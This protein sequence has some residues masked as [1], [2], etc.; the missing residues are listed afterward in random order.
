M[1]LA[2]LT[3]LS[4]QRDEFHRA[5]KRL[6]GL[7]YEESRVDAIAAIAR[8]VDE[9]D[10]LGNEGDG[11]ILKVAQ[12]LQDK[13]A[14]GLMLV[15]C[16][17]AERSGLGS[18]GL[19]QKE[20]QALIEVGRLGEAVRRAKTLAAGT[21]YAKPGT[22]DYRIWSSAMGNVGR[23]YK[24]GYMNAA[25]NRV[26]DPAAPA[27]SPTDLERSVEIYNAVWERSKRDVEAHP[28]VVR[29]PSTYHGIN[30]AALIIR[31]ERDRANPF[32]GQDAEEF[33][34]ASGEAARTLAEDILAVHEEDLKAAL[35]PGTRPGDIWTLATCGEAYLVLGYDSDAAL[36]YG[37]YAGNP[38]NDAFKIA[39]SLR[40]LEEVWGI[41]GDDDDTRGQIVRILKTALLNLQKGKQSAVA[42][43]APEDVVQTEPVILTPVE[44]GLIRRDLEK[45]RE[46]A[47]DPTDGYQ[48][49]FNKRDEVTQ[50]GRMMAMD[51][52]LGAM[53]RLR[54]I[55]AIETI[56]GSDW[57][58]IGSG[59]FVDGGVFR[60]DWAGQPLIATNYH[61]VGG[62]DGVMA[63]SYQR[64]R[65]VFFEYDPI[66]RTRDETAI[67][68][69]AVAWMSKPLHHDITLLR[70]K[71]PLPANAKPLMPADVSDYLPV[72][73]ALDEDGCDYNVVV[74]GFPLGGEPKFSF[75]DELL[76]DHSVGDPAGPVRPV[77][78]LDGRPEQLHYRTPTE[79]GSSG[80]PVFDS[81]SWALIGIHHKGS[82]NLKRIPSKSGRYEA[83]QGI[84]IPSIRAAINTPAAVM[85]DTGGD[86]A[87]DV[88]AETGAEFA[89]VAGAV[90]GAVAGQIASRIGST[91]YPDAS[92]T[93]RASGHDTV[94]MGKPLGPP[95]YSA[96]STPPS[97]LIIPGRRI[98]QPQDDPALLERL[99]K[100]GVYS[101]D[102][103]AFRMK[104]SGFET[105]IGDDNRT[106]IHA[107][108]AYP[109]RMICSL[110]MHWEGGTQTVG[111]GFLVGQRTVLTAGHCI[112]PSRGSPYPTGIE[113]RPGRA[114][115]HEPFAHFGSLYAEKV[116]LH[117]EWSNRFDPRFDVGALHLN[118]EIGEELGWFRVAARAPDSLKKQWVHVTGYPGDKVTRLGEGAESLYAAELW[119]HAT[120]V[121]MVHDGRVYY[122][123]DTF[124]GQSGSPVYTYDKDGVATVVGV[125]AYG[126]GTSGPAYAFENNSAGW[127]DAGLLQIISDWRT[128]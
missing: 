36:C 56:D 98:T 33:D 43:Q 117:G 20:V 121:E 59:F 73:G 61:V 9:A 25:A 93:P 84:W 49:Y 114:G 119:H 42:G 101:G 17:L 51:R 78:N 72:R 31:A 118:R 124:G 75:D 109:F 62:S 86:G 107:T 81:A 63:A 2:A 92:A 27:P 58:Q 38:E 115:Q 48:A 34:W 71:G 83:N 97:S 5:R 15:L 18:D 32:E 91:D 108:A 40:Q 60:D 104:S 29:A 37:A 57:V 125:H 21:A 80:S 28:D 105:V 70:P 8:V 77:E 52:L 82:P 19:R 44:A 39:S 122:P 87:S 22:A 95:G 65:A 90:I 3:D 30:A 35:Q 79:P 50:T 120:P 116:S 54:S 67:S 103:D 66:Q 6:M 99:L 112:L 113:I 24:Q 12:T 53:D 55:C 1:T 16:I 47:H 68:F 4:V 10:D 64:S 96:P 13:R 123:A 69:E 76:L 74:L 126:T 41:S 111:T 127:V 102:L 106:Q 89:G 7:G 46:V 100:T 128:L 110:T 45:A 94:V 85:G 26:E 88:G 23:A 14:F 11:E